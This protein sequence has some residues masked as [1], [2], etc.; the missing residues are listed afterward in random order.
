MRLG[1][2]LTFVFTALSTFATS[3]VAIAAPQ[4]SAPTT[5][6]ATDAPVDFETQVLP[7]FKR[8]CVSC[9][10][11]EKAQG[12]LQ[13][14]SAHRLFKGGI[15]DDIVVP[16]DARKSYL[17]QRMRGEGGEDLMPLKKPALPATELALIERW[18]DQGAK[19]DDAGPPKFVP[20][21]GG[22]KRLTL[23][24]YQNTIQDV[25]GPNVTVPT[26]IEPDTLVAGSAS[27]GAARVGVSGHGIEK[28]SVAGFAL[29]KQAVADANFLTRYAPCAATEAPIDEPCARA[30]LDRFGLRAWR[31]PL[32]AAEVARYVLLAADVTRAGRPAREALVAMTG[33]LLQSPNFL[34]RSE[35]GVP[36][37]D[38]PSRRRLNDYELASRL[39]YFIWGAPPDD[40]LLAAAASGVLGTDAGL[41]AQSS[42]MLQSPRAKEALRGFFIELFRLRRLDRI[43]ENRAKYPQ[44][45]KTIGSSMKGETLRL[46]EEVAFDPKRDFRD[47]FSTGFTYVNAE[48]AKL[49]GINA[50]ALAGAKPDQ[51]V[52]VPIPAGRQG[53]LS[54]GSFLTIF[55]HQTTSSPTR[56]GKFIRESLLCQ[57][58][59][60]PP[61]SVDTKLPK[62]EEGKPRTTRQKLEHHR[63]NDR[64]KGCHK[65]MDPLGLAF[66]NFDG[67]GAYRAKEHGMPIDTTGEV[68]GTPF[69]TPAELGALLA[70]NPKIGAC[71]A[72]GLFRFAVGHLESEGE[73]PLME[74]L[75]KGLERDGYYFPSLVASVIKS[76]GFRTISVPSTSGKLAAK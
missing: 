29:A 32:D 48:L 24:Q 66:E 2:S 18:I 33:A 55:A 26:H 36:F 16:G 63:N 60:P 52:R 61:P 49:Y 57:A 70:K 10:G 65:A 39:S 71:V 5:A 58:V 20:A 41:H 42:R 73:E 17:V 14:V 4:S 28:Y 53:L 25:L 47:I 15:G 44:Y 43:N 40:E 62:D 72:R 59:P 67:I 1:G 54:Q 23:L 8:A 19:V 9:H 22:L 11:P 34:Y 76:E 45:T 51:Y 46:I 75:A 74:A 35:T 31:R 3:A 13:L 7:I 50:A 64:C 38:D 30:F 37:G 69:K 56:R 21:P 27:V 68:D 6:G 12:G